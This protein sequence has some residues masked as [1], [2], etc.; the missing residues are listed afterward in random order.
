MPQNPAR[1]ART[2]AEILDHAG[3]LFRLRGHAGT[4]IDDVMLAAGLTR[5]TFYAH[6]KSKD[7]LFAE[8]IGTGQGLLWK[9]RA[10][11]AEVLAVLDAYLAKE[12]LAA[13]AQD[14]TLAALPADVTRGPL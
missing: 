1:K 3:R 8:V 7:E 10:R 6:F 13:T 12:D 11:D 4:N 2:R 5:G 14:C 9:L